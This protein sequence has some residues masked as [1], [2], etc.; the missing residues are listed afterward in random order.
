MGCGCNILGAFSSGGGGGVSL[1]TQSIT[2]T[3][4]QTT[5]SSS[6]VDISNTSITL[7]DEDNGKAL[8][9]A[10]I[11]TSTSNQNTN[12]VGIYYDGADKESS[13]Q[14]FA[15][16]IPYTYTILGITDTDG[17]TTKC[18]W[19]QSSN[20]ATLQAGTYQTLEIY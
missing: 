15:A 17:G 20:T 5:T 6:F 2:A 8:L 19:K 3:A 16:A 18:R 7:P 13:T 1:S 9:I 4:D 10:Q 14:N 12:V 11:T